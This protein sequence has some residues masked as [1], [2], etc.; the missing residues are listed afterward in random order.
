MVRGA[1]SVSGGPVG[2]LGRVSLPDVGL[3]RLLT[4]R[5]RRMAASLPARVAITVLLLGIVASHIDWEQMAGRIRN[6]H[7]L[8]FV[9][10]VGL[11]LIA[12]VVGA[13]RWWLL[14]RRADVHLGV[15]RLA[16][17]Y[18]VST[19]SGTFLPTA[20][21][22]DVTR[23][24]LVAR[25]GPVLTRVAT[26]IVT[27]RAGGL[28]GL[29]GMAWIAFACNASKVPNGAR[30]FLLWV[31]AVSVLGAGMVLVALWR[32]P[33]LRGGSLIPARLGDAARESWKLLQVY[34]RDVPMLM[35][36]VLSSLCFQALISLQL[37]MLADSIGIDL[38]FATAAV[39]LALVTVVTLV[40]ISIGGFGVREG[41]YVVLL[42]GASIAATDAALISILS[43]AALFLASLP[44]AYML[45]RGGLAPAMEAS[46]L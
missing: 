29:L 45:A 9:V 26:T 41:T 8:D 32:K 22:G 2:I 27:D 13:W 4:G 38:P 19:F 17:V 11:V 25:G 44:G 14:L 10:A 39:A 28:F 36:V 6:G 5:A 18:A 12:L 30:T 40:P 3:A 15:G 43:V 35:A 7:P 31:S 1:P 20:V 42:G 23:A 16:R 34:A 37:V 24:L 46:A 21:G 33:R